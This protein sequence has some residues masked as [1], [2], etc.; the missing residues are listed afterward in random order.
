MSI[1][2][3]NNHALSSRFRS[4]L[5]C[6]QF[7][8]RSWTVRPCPAKA[9]RRGYR[10]K[11]CAAGFVRRQPGDDISEQGDVI[12]TTIHVAGDRT[13]HF[14]RPAVRGPARGRVLRRPW[15]LR[16]AAARRL[17]V[18]HRT[19]G[20]RRAPR[21]HSRRRPSRPAAA[22]VVQGRH[23]AGDRRA[24]PDR[25]PVAAGNHDGD[26]PAE[27][28]RLC[29]PASAPTSPCAATWSPLRIAPTPRCPTSGT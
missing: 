12:V 28:L 19:D 5:D 9:L 27:G 3:H 14:A 24:G 4:A 20:R 25:P 7:D 23:R 2:F 1:V 26:R 22:G 29:R 13:Y 10:I 16:R 17:R 11:I 15:L 21:P 8:A 18:K 6:G